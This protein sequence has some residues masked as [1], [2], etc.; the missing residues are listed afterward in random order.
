MNL[1]WRFQ[2]DQPCTDAYSYQPL[3][4]NSSGEIFW[5]HFDSKVLICIEHADGV[6]NIATHLSRKHSYTLAQRQAIIQKYAQ[7]E[8]L[9]PQQV[10]LPPPQSA[11][12]TALGRPLVGLV[13]DKYECE[14]ISINQSTIRH[15]CNKVHGWTSSKDDTAYW[16]Q[17]PV[18]TFFQNA[19]SRRYFIVREDKDKRKAALSGN[20]QAEIQ[21]I[22][23]EWSAARA[24]HE[25]EL[26]FLD[27]EII[28]QDRTGWF[29][30]T[31][32]P[33]HLGKRHLRF[34]A[35][36]SRLPDREELVLREVVRVSDLLMNRA[37]AGLFTFDIELRRWIKSCQQGEPDRRPIA[38]LQN[39]DSQDRYTGYLRRFAC[40]V[41][42]VWAS[43]QELDASQ[44]EINGISTSAARGQASP[45]ASSDDEG[46]DND[47]DT[48][49]EEEDDNDEN[50][51][52]ISS[53]ASEYDETSEEGEPTTVQ[54]G[55]QHRPANPIVDPMQ[56][57]RELFPWHGQQ[58]MLIREFYDLLTSKDRSVTD[59]ARIRKMAEVYHSFIFHKVGG[60][61]FS[62]GLIHFLAVLGI[63]E[64]NNRLRRAVDYSY[65]LAGMVYNIRVLGAELLLPAAKREQQIDDLD[66]REAFLEQRRR[67]L[68]DG[69][70][71]P[72]SIMI[73]LLAY[74]KYV[75]MNTGNTG[76]VTWSRDKQ[77]LYFRG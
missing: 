30:R 52:D 25:H 48:G 67:F 63:D 7:Y 29:H 34:L 31:D 71:T 36:A 58:K 28:Q 46:S 76:S 15:H 14:V 6:Q 32:W 38:R 23:S 47:D 13:C 3:G 40:Y 19:A 74:G 70:G 54:D 27:A 18:Q 65:M 50:D 45:S 68:A 55:S 51:E 17:A 2:A 62:S 33:Q 61:Q 41:F 49:D 10:P 72:M 57:A 4:N 8:R 24:V 22:R 16:H 77:T 75:A 35:Q 39:P 37:V 43:E 9:P 44:H 56:D 64:D 21:Q 59:G 20:V 1:T 12:I 5:Y 66:G 53:A 42:R 11:P 60:K 26:E 73:S 69:T